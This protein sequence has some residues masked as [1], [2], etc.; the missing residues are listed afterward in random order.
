MKELEKIAG[1][2]MP[3]KESDDYVAR[4]IAQS[5]DKAVQSNRK[6]DKVV[7]FALG[8]VS[9]AAVL[10]AGLMLF[11]GLNA[12][13]DYERIQNSMSLSEVLNSMTEEELM[14]INCYAIED[15]PEYEE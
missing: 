14:S 12:E 13:S 11:V 7:R 9:A 1:K 6:Q 15:L 4:L 3:Y 5:A 2:R 8:I 10:A